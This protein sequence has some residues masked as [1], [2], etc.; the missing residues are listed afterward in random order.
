MLQLTVV[1]FTSYSD[2]FKLSDYLSTARISFYSDNNAESYNLVMPTE[3]YD[4][5]KAALFFD[6]FAGIHVSSFELSL[7]L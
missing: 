3:V 2:W 6:A 4:D 5:L 7:A 1:S